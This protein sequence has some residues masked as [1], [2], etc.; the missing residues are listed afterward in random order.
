[1]SEIKW[2][3]I[4]DGNWM[5]I[6]FLLKNWKEKFHLEG[7]LLLNLKLYDQ[8]LFI[9]FIDFQMDRKIRW[10]LN[11]GNIVGNLVRILLLSWDE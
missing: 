9:Y 8:V 7:V 3:I 1:M 5:K 11:L 10:K 6:L 2:N 4:S